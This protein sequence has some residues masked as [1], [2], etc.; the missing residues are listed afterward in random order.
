MSFSTAQRH[1]TNPLH[2]DANVP[3]RE[4]VSERGSRDAG[5]LVPAGQ[6][7]EGGTTAIQQQ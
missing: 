1:E 6:G 2:R 5:P 4:E 7:L 3:S